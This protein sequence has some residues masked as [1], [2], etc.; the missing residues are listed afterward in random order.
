MPTT[1]PLFV[2]IVRDLPLDYRK[3]FIFL[4]FIV[5]SVISTNLSAQ[6]EWEDVD[7]SKL[8]WS[9]SNN[10]TVHSRKLSYLSVANTIAET[11]E[12]KKNHRWHHE[13]ATLYMIWNERNNH[14][15]SFRIRNNNSDPGKI[16]RVYETKKG[17][18]VKKWHKKSVYWGFAITVNNKSGGTSTFTQYFA[19]NKYL[20]NIYTYTSSCNDNHE[21]APSVNPK[22]QTIRLTYDG[23]EIKLYG[24]NGYTLINT[25]RNATSVSRIEILAGTAA[26][27]DVTD[28]TLKKQTTYGIVKPLIETAKQ[29]LGK[30]EFSS[31]VRT[32]TEIIG[33]YG[34]RNAE[35]YTMRA[36]AYASQKM[37][38]AAI[39][40][41]T[42]ALTYNPSF[43]DAY[44]IR[45]L[46]KLMEDDDAGV[47]DLRKAGKRGAAV[48]KESG[49]ENYYPSSQ[50]QN[51]SKK[52]HN[53][54]KSTP[55]RLLK[56]DP[57][58]K[59]E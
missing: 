25:F 18:I 58:F 49:L 48:L 15:I 20:N 56:K 13:N 40:D 31:A 11:K 10:L 33:H 42:E 9:I 55:K 47:N 8:S 43:E 32:L 22:V 45:G 19:D 23:K 35:I 54:R 21:W 12:N 44:Y 3:P 4:L 30:Q 24:G 7:A 5:L 50:S 51:S 29:Q 36:F 38:K 1:F 57:N 26:W 17:K 16:Y 46:C 6:A 34:Y 39:K 52:G 37:N 41:C 27:I 14:E 59:I 28:L 53:N 2:M